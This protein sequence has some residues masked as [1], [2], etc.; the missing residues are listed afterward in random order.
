L[1]FFKKYNSLDNFSLG[2]VY[3]IVLCGIQNLRV[4]Y[5][6]LPS[7][8]YYFQVLLKYMIVYSV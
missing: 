5:G 8:I 7:S 6:P 4:W 2:G 1:P 3:G